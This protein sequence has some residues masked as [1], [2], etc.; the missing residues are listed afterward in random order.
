MKS[1]LMSAFLIFT[2]PFITC[3]KVINLNL[4]NASPQI[5]IIGEVTN[6]P[7]PYQVTINSTVNFSN[8]NVFPPVSGALVII[9]DNTGLTDSLT[10]TT[11]GTYTTHSSWQGKP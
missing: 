2:I 11:P 9:T 8:S 3:K 7:G 6:P 10:E 1:L 4:K 5:V